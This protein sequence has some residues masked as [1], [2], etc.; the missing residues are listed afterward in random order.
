[1]EKYTM[2]MDW[3]NQYCQNDYTTQSSL[4]FFNDP[5]DVG[6]LI[7]GSSAFSKSY[8]HIWKFSVHL[9]LKLI[10]FR[11]LVYIFWTYLNSF[12]IASCSHLTFGFLHFVM[13]VFTF[14]NFIKITPL[15]IF[16]KFSLLILFIVCIFLPICH[17]YS[18]GFILVGF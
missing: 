13:L 2:F 18:F 17:I 6:N 16:N 15:L 14:Q 5:A 4:A 9:L 12:G 8:L 11:V 1:M 10:F 7:S 3:K